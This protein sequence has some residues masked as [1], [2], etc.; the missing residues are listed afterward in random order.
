MGRV[1]EPD[2]IAAAVAGLLSDANHWVTGQRIEI[3]GGQSL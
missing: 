1:G 3:S 2:D